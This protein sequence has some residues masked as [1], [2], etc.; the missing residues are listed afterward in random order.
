MT[1]ID[2]LATPPVPSL[3]PTPPPAAPA[4]VASF[5]SLSA[6]YVP[7]EPARRALLDPQGPF[8]SP[9]EAAAVL[10]EEL[11]RELTDLRARFRAVDAS[12]A[13]AQGDLVR[14]RDALEAVGVRSPDLGALLADV[15]M[16]RR[17]LA[18]MD[19]RLGDMDQGVD[20][21]L[22]LARGAW[23]SA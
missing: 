11:A 5:E 8:F 16:R 6:T 22:R 10:G 2:K 9:H 20:R 1:R 14:A 21:S 17:E 19:E 12:L 23:R 7:Q 13:Q 18:R 15:E 4:P 3:P